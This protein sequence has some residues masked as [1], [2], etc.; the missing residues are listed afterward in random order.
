MQ[1]ILIDKKSEHGIIKERLSVIRYPLSVIRYPLK[2]CL[3]CKN[4]LIISRPPRHRLYGGTIYDLWYRIDN[5][6]KINF[7][8]A[9]GVS[10]GGFYILIN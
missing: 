3:L 10:A 8:E 9:A 5:I 2:I 6:S 4:N 1:N 7:S